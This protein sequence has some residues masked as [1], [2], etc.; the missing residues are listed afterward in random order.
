L[1]A[2]GTTQYALRLTRVYQQSQEDDCSLTW[3]AEEE[4]ER[5]KIDDEN[6]TFEHSGGN[7]NNFEY[8]NPEFSFEKLEN[9]E[10]KDNHAKRMKELKKWLEA[11]TNQSDLQKIRVVRLYSV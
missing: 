9:S 7:E 11:I 1:G 6:S 10:T 2:T 3:I 8:E 5:L 4:T